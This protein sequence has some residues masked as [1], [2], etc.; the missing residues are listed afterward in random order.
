MF[1]QTQLNQYI[2]EVRYRGTVDYELKQIQGLLVN[3]EKRPLPNK[4][5]QKIHISKLTQLFKALL[6]E[7]AGQ[8]VVEEVRE[9]NTSNAQYSSTS[10]THNST[11]GIGIWNI[12]KQKVAWSG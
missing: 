11:G 9:D 7:K 1:S 5:A 12:L 6:T 10:P 3:A 8:K 4:D 2:L